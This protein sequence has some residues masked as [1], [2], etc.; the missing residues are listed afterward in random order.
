MKRIVIHNLRPEYNGF[1]TV[2][3]GWPTQPSLVELENMLANQEAL[4]KQMSGVTIKDE[5]EALFTNKKKG[6]SRR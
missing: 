6:T 1:M 5:Y 2:V 3:R 4:A